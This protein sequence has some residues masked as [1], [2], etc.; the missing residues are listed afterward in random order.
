M[1]R[2]AGFCF[3]TVGL[4]FCHPSTADIPSGREWSNGVQTFR[5]QVLAPLSEHFKDQECVSDLKPYMIEVSAKASEV[6]PSIDQ[7]IYIL[8]REA[9]VATTEE[10]SPYQGVIDCETADWWPLIHTLIDKK[11]EFLAN[12]FAIVK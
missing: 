11:L 4:L 6:R 3:I 12:V 10:L 7:K 8:I 9:V 2:L 1:Q 5:Q